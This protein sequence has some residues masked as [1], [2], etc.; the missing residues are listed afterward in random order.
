MKTL[1][2]A[3]RRSVSENLSKRYEKIYAAQGFN[4][5]NAKLR[6]RKSRDNPKI[7]SCNMCRNPRRSAYYKLKDKITRQESLQVLREKEA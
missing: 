1:K 6:A 7:C 2:R 4:S 3:Q 5:N